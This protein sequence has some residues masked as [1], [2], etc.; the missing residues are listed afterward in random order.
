MTAYCAPTVLRTSRFRIALPQQAARALLY[1]DYRNNSTASRMRSSYALHL[2]F[3]VA[4]PAIQPHLRLSVT[5]RLRSAF[6]G[7]QRIYW[8]EVEVLSKE[9]HSRFLA[10]TRASKSMIATPTVMAESATLNAGQ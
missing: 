7:G 1:H 4:I 8:P 6:H 2:F 3:S 5:N 10:K 9:N